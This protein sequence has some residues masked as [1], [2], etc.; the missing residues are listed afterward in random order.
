MSTKNLAKL[1]VLM[2]QLS[3]LLQGASASEKEFGEMT[4]RVIDQVGMPEK[5]WQLA[6]QAADKVFR[7]AG[8]SLTWSRCVR[9]R[10]TDNS[11]CTQLMRTN[12]VNL[13]I[14]DEQS[15][16]RLQA[17]PGVF[18]AALTTD[19]G[20][21]SRAYVY[22][23]RIQQ[24]CG[25]HH[26]VKEPFLLGAVV[27]HELGHLLLGPNSHSPWGIMKPD[28]ERTDMTGISLSALGFDSRQRE[29]LYAAVARR[30]QAAYS[31]ETN[32]NAYRAQAT[33]WSAAR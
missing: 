2:I 27:A 12:E 30:V 26:D 8:V 3:M 22:F 28:L 10:T 7:S 9:N 11:D 18:G 6:E 33:A 19:D 20:F 23:G 15:A 13:I 16:K 32:A 17:A 29:A 31:Q 21:G 24:M 25:V 5:E 14:V 1:A 4:I